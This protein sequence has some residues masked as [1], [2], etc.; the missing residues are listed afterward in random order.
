MKIIG[1]Q[2][3]VPSST[4]DRSLHVMSNRSLGVFDFSCITVYVQVRIEYTNKCS[5]N[6]LGYRD[7]EFRSGVL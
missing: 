1:F 6:Y 4:T 2:Y 5:L 7:M 3:L